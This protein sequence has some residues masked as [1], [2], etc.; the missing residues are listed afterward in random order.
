MTQLTEFL[1][2][3]PQPSRWPTVIGVISLIYALGGLLC[4]TSLGAWVILGDRLPEV[5]RAGMTLPPAL[6]VMAMIQAFL[7]LIVGTILLVGAVNLLRRR[8]SGVK[9]LKT[10]AFARVL[11]VLLSA[12]ITVLNAPANIQMQHESVEWTKRY[13]KE[14]N[15]S[16]PVPE[17]TDQELWRR[18]MIGLAVQSVLLS[19]FPV[20]V[21]SYLSRKKIDAAV[22]Q[23]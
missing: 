12:V 18:T 17:Y 1:E 13:F 9:M 22:S 5:W 2:A 10:W 16:R 3:E 4:Q 11:L 8:R 23:W 15:V 14:N 20:F 19:A 21:G 7:G 6:K